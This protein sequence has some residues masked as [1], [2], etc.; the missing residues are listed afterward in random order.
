MAVVSLKQLLE[1]GVH[2]GHQTRRWNPKMRRFIFAERNGIYII[3]LLKTLRGIEAAYEYCRKLVAGGGIVLFVGT[4]KQI[5]DAVAEEAKRVSMPYVNY[6]WLGG[7]LTNF[8]TIHKRILRMR[9]LESMEAQG[10]LDEMP[11]K[12]ALVLRKELEKLQKNL[13]GIRDLNRR[14]DAVFIVDTRKEDIAVREAR[15]LGL[16]II[17]IVDTNCDP[18]DVDYV[19]PGN[20]DAIR[21]GALLTRVVADA[22]AAGM[23][24][25]PP[26]VIAAAEAAAAS[27]VTLTA[28]SEE[29]PAEWEIMLAQQETENKKGKEPAPAAAAKPAQPATRAPQPAPA[30]EAPAEEPDGEDPFQR[31]LDDTP[32]PGED[33]EEELKA[34]YKD[35]DEVKH[36]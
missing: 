10:I 9:E 24:A 19:I 14:P 28:G 34:K 17:A 16:P 8:Q 33:I 2:F 11:K 20:D 27:S 23:Q 18:D 32:L 21:S 15:K 12:E 1:A 7:M 31:L 22:I 35:E 13:D 25:R 6:R 36:R 3:D 5:A 4:K 29:P 26:E 30:A